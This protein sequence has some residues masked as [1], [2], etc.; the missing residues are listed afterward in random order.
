MKKTKIK[1]IPMFPTRYFDE[2]KKELVKSD[3]LSHANYSGEILYGDPIRDENSAFPK[4]VKIEPVYIDNIPWED[5]LIYNSFYR[6]RSAAGL[7]FKNSK[8]Q[9]FT[10]FMKDIDIFIPRMVKGVIKDTFIY[11]KRGMNY[12][13]TIY[14]G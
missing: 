6:G 13:V 14:E 1:K 8:G 7:I 3:I 12:G 11:C 9:I 10:V 4:W 5:E 2:N